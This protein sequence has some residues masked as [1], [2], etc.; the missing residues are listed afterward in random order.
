MKQLASNH[1]N[2]FKSTCHALLFNTSKGVLPLY[3]AKQYC[4]DHTYYI[5]KDSD[6]FNQYSM[7]ADANDYFYFIL[8]D[9]LDKSLLQRYCADENIHLQTLE[10]ACPKELIHDLS[11]DDE[12]KY[13][14]LC[15]QFNEML[16]NANL[17]VSTVAKSFLPTLSSSMTSTNLSIVI[18]GLEAVLFLFFC[19]SLLNK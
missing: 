8:E 17:S 3:E 15:N 18:L 2:L 6:M 5:L 16:H 14:S 11:N 10:Q 19:C 4:E 1:D 12:K 9:N 7:L 13:Q